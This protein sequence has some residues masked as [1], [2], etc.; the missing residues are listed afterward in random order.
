MQSRWIN[1]Y[2]VITTSWYSMESKWKVYS[3]MGLSIQKTSHLTFCS[4]NF[5]CIAAACMSK[6]SLLTASVQ[7]DCAI[8]CGQLS[9]IVCGL[10]HLLWL[11]V[12]NCMWFAPSIVANCVKL[13]AAPSTRS[14]SRTFFV[15]TWKKKTLS[16]IFPSTK[17][18][19][20]SQTLKTL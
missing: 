7:H 20:R 12:R 17:A 19:T 2:I 15:A 11:I 10:R 4:G 9:A 6:Q 14:A 8:Y 13:A 16:C 5:P 3:T 1:Y 18:C